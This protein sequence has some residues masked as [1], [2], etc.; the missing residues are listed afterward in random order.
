MTGEAGSFVLRVRLID[1][2]RL[3]IVNPNGSIGLSQ[4]C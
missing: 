2:N 4:R 1:G 3:R